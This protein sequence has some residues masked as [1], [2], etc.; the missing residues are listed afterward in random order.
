[1]L[2]LTYGSSWNLLVFVFLSYF[3]PVMD[4]SLA[5]DGILR[6][7]DYAYITFEGTYYGAPMKIYIHM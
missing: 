3:C 7:G 5:S 2:D 4:R 6:F 1:M